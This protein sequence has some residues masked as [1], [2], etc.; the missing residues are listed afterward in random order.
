[1]DKIGFWNVRGMNKPGKL[2]DV[3]WFLRH[4]NMGFFGLLE[5]KVRVKNF[6]KVFNNFGS[7]W[8]VIT[9]HYVSKYSRIWITWL[10]SVFSVDSCR[11]DFQFIHVCVTHV[12]LRKKFWLTMVYGLNTALERESLWAQIAQIAPPANTPWILCG[13][14]NNILNLE[15]RIGSQCSLAEVEQFSNCLRVYSLFDFKVGG[16]FYTWTNKQ[17]GDDRVCTK[18]DKAEF[19]PG[20]LTEHSPCCMNLDSAV[21]NVRK[22][23]RFFN[24]WTKA[25]NFLA[26]VKDAWDRPVQGSATFRVVKKLKVVKQELKALN[27]THFSSIEGADIAAGKHLVDIQRKLNVDPNN[28]RLR[29]QEH[30]ARVAYN[31]A[32]TTRFMLLKQKAKTHWLKEGDANSS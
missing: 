6:G 11:I 25:Q 28:A 10:P 27:L 8:S 31:K 14:F 16:M 22:P 7:D 18:T 30:E 5:T 29:N 9:N 20:G 26:I 21:G 4:H 13:D 17:E 15:D 2:C 32:H 19:L 12:A 24:M 1:M 3:L 23:F